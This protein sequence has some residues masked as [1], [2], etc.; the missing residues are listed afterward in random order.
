MLM[1]SSMIKSIL[2]PNKIGI[3]NVNP[4]VSKDNTIEANN[5]KRY[6]PSSCINFLKVGVLI[7]FFIL[8]TPFFWIL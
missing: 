4:T 2:S 3:Y 6:L 7:F 8:F 5:K 1:P